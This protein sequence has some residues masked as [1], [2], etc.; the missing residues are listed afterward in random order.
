M[1]VLH[2]VGNVQEGGGVQ[3]WLRDLLQRMDLQRFSVDVL[4]YH[5]LDT[6][7][8][9]QLREMGCRLYSLCSLRHPLGF[10]RDLRRSLRREDGYDI[11]HSSIGAAGGLVMK[12]AHA[13]GVPVRI[14]HSRGARI[15]RRDSIWWHLC[16]KVLRSWMLTH[17]SNLLAISRDAAVA[18]Y[19]ERSLTDPRVQISPSGVDL[20]PFARAYNG[21]EVR[22]ELGIPQDAIVI[23]NVSRLTRI[24]NHRRML[25]ITL[26]LQRQ[27]EPVWALVVGDGPMRQQ[28]EQWGNELG[29]SDRLVLTG[30]RNDVPRLMKGAMDVFLFPS[31]HE[32]LGRVAIEAQAAGLPCVMSQAIPQEVDVVEQ[33]VHRIR[34]SQPVEEWAKLI[35]EAMRTGQ[36][37][38]ATDCYDQ[39]AQ[40]PLNIVNVAKQLEQIYERGAR[41]QGR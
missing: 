2:V 13:V 7:G 9:E 32:G 12:E 41:P 8:A 24:K 29:L 3:T 25:E 6:S 36:K 14:V 23:G 4:A 39:V 30:Y 28:I 10:L 17:A 19:E 33:L 37:V 11:V 26:E 1:R 34:L 18:L 35:M 5:G 22:A 15:G 16:V 40:S 27:G 38:D 31:K 21:S 20:S